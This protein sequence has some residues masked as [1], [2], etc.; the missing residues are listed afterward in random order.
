MAIVQVTK[1]QYFLSTQSRLVRHQGRVPEMTNPDPTHSNSSLFWLSA[2]QAD[3]RSLICLIRGE[4][5]YSK[6]SSIPSIPPKKFRGEIIDVAEVYQQHWKEKTGQWLENVDQTHLV[7]V[8][9]SQYYKKHSV[10]WRT[11][12]WW[13]MARFARW[14]TFLGSAKRSRLSPGTSRA[15]GA[16]FHFSSF[17]TASARLESVFRLFMIPMQGW[18]N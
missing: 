8:G 9:A 13:K 5:Y 6:Q 17:V 12:P 4:F 15:H 1:D 7:L 3:T 16:P 11:F 2:K 14:I 18:F 10:R